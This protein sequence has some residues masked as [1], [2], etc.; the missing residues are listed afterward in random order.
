MIRKGLFEELGVWG[1]Q[2][3]RKS[4]AQVGFKEGPFQAE[5]PESPQTL[6]ETLFFMLLG[7]KGPCHQVT[8][9]L[10]FKH[11]V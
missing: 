6:G 1:A 5:A 3:N 2:N 11:R 9:P 10:P 8:Y 4:P 7:Q